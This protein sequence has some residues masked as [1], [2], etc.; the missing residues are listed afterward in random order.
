MNLYSKT[1]RNLQV[2]LRVWSGGQI[3]SKKKK[4]C[5]HIK[6][7]APPPLIT[8]VKLIINDHKYELQENTVLTFLPLFKLSLS[9]L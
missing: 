8:K 2:G 5:G 6:T 1:F 7:P 4:N 3:F 9:L